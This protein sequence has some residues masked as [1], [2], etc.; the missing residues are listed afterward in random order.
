MLIKITD[1]LKALVSKLWHSIKR[2]P[3]ALFMASALVIV[4]IILN[5]NNNGLSSNTLESLK[6]LAMVFALG[7]P[8][9]L[10]VK[11]FFERIPKFNITYKL[12]VYGLALIFQAIYYFFLL[13]N[14]DFIP[15][16]RYVAI[17]LSLYLLFLIIPQIKNKDTYEL[18]VISLLYRFIITYLYSGILYGGI[19][20]IVSAVNILFSVKIPQTLYLDILYIIAGIFAPMFFLGDIP[21]TEKKIDLVNYPKVFKVLLLY[22]VM[23]ILGIYS[24]ILYAY[25]ILNINPMKPTRININIGSMLLWYALIS[26]AITFFAYPLRQT[27]KWAKSFMAFYPKLILP[28]LAML[29][30]RISIRTYYYG[31]TERRYYVIVAGLWVTGSMIYLALKHNARNIY[32]IISLAVISTLTVS[33]PWSSYSVSTSSQNHRIETILNQNKMIQNNTIVISGQEVS[34][35]DKENISSIIMYFDNT[36]RLNKIKYLPKDFSLNKMKD[37][38]GFEITYPQGNYNGTGYFNL[39]PSTGFSAENIKDYDYLLDLPGNYNPSDLNYSEGSLTFKYSLA[40]RKLTILQ[41]NTAIYSKNIDDIASII[42]NKNPQASSSGKEGT[43]TKDQMTFVDEN[44]KLKVQYE[45][46][47]INGSIDNSGK[48]VVQYVQFRALVKVK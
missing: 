14:F 10:S 12:C 28:L 22:I 6:R 16:T 38:F 26:T 15:V 42:Y 37:V 4:L 1:L 19:M 17:S 30:V 2:F 5:H 43:L 23:P 18:Y 34:T 33:G 45:F 41:N 11:A 39:M 46:S 40:N 9:Y 27:S 35:V 3:E 7:I 25:F 31:F 24:L 32:L 36:N 8:L 44:D 21:E 13:K 47:N 20:A 48:P 29:L